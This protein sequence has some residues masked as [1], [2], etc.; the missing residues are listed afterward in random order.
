MS[1]VPPVSLLS[2][3]RMVALF[4]A[5]FPAALISWIIATFV[6]GTGSKGGVLN[7][8]HFHMVGHEIYISWTLFVAM[9][10]L[11]WAIFMMME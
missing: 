10:G 3:A 6:A 2:E 4:K 9:V 1:G 8:Q 7:I 11:G 5:L